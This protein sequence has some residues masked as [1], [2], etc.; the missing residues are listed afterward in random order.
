MK[1]VSCTSLCVSLARLASSATAAHAVP[2]EHRGVLVVFTVPLRPG[3]LNG[4]L[5]QGSTIDLDMM[6]RYLWNAQE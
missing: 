3:W 4:Y 5:G 6:N 2:N 1:F